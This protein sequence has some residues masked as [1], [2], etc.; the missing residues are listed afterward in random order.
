MTLPFDQTEGLSHPFSVGDNNHAFTAN[1]NATGAPYADI[2]ARNDDTAFQVTENLGKAVQVGNYP[3]AQVY[4]LLQVTPSVEWI[5]LGTTN[6]IDTFLELTDVLETTYTGF[7]LNAVR[8]NAAGTGL[9]FTTDDAGDVIGPGSSVDNSV[10]TFDGLTGKII[11]DQNALFITDADRVGI[12]INLPDSLLHSHIGTA[13][14]VSPLAGTNLTLES[15]TTQYLSF[16]TPDANTSG[17]LFGHEVNNVHGG[18]FY[19]LTNG[20][21]FRNNGNQNVLCLDQN[22]RVGIGETVPEAKL[23]V[24]LGSAGVTAAVPG[25]TLVLESNT[26]NFLQFFYPNANGG[27][28][29]F[30][31]PDVNIAGAFSYNTNDDFTWAT[32]NNAVKMTLDSGGSLAVGDGAAPLA[33]TSI[34]LKANNA[35]LLLNNL[36]STQRDAL[37]PLEGMTIWNTTTAQVENYDGVSWVA[38][39]GGDVSGPPSSLINSIATFLDASGKNIISTAC[40]IDPITG[41]MLVDSTNGIPLRIRMDGA[42]GNP[43][44]V[45]IEDNILRGQ[46]GYFGSQGILG[47]VT[48]GQIG[49]NTNGG[50]EYA[51]RSNFNGGGHRFSTANAA[52]DDLILRVQIE[53][54]TG[55][56][57]TENINV[58]PGKSLYQEVYPNTDRQVLALSCQDQLDRSSLGNDMALLGSAIIVEGAGRIGKGL[59]LDGSLQTVGRITETPALQ[60]TDK[61]SVEFFIFPNTNGASFCPVVSKMDATAAKGWNVTYQNNTIRITLRD[62]P[63]L[64]DFT[65]PNPPGLNIPTSQWTHVAFTFDEATLTAKT[66]FNGK[67]GDSRTVSQGW[68]DSATDLLLGARFFGGIIGN[69]LDGD[70]SNIFVY[71]EVLELEEIRSHYLDA[72]QFLNQSSL[73]ADRYKITDTTFPLAATG[74]LTLTG[75]ALDTETVTIDTKVY[76]FQTVLTDVDGNVFIGASAAATISNLVQ[77]IILGPGSGVAYAASTTLHP[78][79]KAAI[80]TGDSVDATARLAG[81]QGNAIAT[82]ETLTNG[83]WAN[84]TLTG[85]V[86]AKTWLDFNKTNRLPSRIGV[87]T[88]EIYSDDDFPNPDVGGARILDSGLYLIKDN[89]TTPTKWTIPFGAIVDIRVEAGFNSIITYTGDDTFIT[90]SF[91]ST[92]NMDDFEIFLTGN[93]NKAFDL[94]GASVSDSMRFGTFTFA[95]SG[96]KIAG[97]FTFTSGCILELVGFIGF[98]EGVTFSSIVFGSV[99]SVNF[100]GD[101]TG[102]TPHMNILGSLFFGFTSR[103]TGSFTGPS[104][105]VFFI[106]PDIGANANVSIS[107]T[108]NLGAGS[109]YKSGATGLITAYADAM[110]LGTAIGSVISG[111]GG[112]ARFNQGITNNLFIGQKINIFG[113]TGGNVVYNGDHIV[114]AVGPGGLEW[115]ETSVNFV[116]TGSG[117]FTAAST[118]VTST[119][120]G[121]SELESILITGTVAYNGGYGIY[122]VLTNTFQINAP[123]ATNEATGTWDTG[124]L[125]QKDNRVDTQDSAGSPNSMNVAFG[126]MNANAS[127]TVIASAD[128]YQAMDYNTIV[129]DPASEL[130]TLIDPMEGIFRYDGVRPVTGSLVASITATKTGSTAIFRFT[131]SINGAVPTF[132]SK[133]YVPIE[134]KTTQVS[135]TLIRPISVVPGD[136]IQ[137]MG[138]EETTTDNITITHFFLQI[139]I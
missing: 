105:S 44:L 3:T 87:Q 109:Y 135:A 45:N 136:T 40:T 95:G 32:V 90:G 122:N 30:G 123:F 53:D 61:L 29:L 119:A 22:G 8:V 28:L 66:Y 31:D 7:E 17:I 81:S 113:F 139:I 104:E 21:Q 51:S 12:G 102:T 55:D 73:I 128:T 106:N 57:K 13:G 33:D 52:L 4:M 1:P 37:T 124:S 70:L 68:T 59:R 134:I 79:V 86:S 49:W 64:T 125:T 100:F 96:D 16:L 18:I 56:M 82:T 25:T 108:N 131:D 36:T 77:A 48:Q 41:Q 20:M 62:D 103:D 27:G 101:G 5:P 46:F 94:T 137:I 99:D 93:D 76:T 71:N 118:T 78:T 9:E 114:T 83:S 120:H 107:R 75:N 2:T 38:M 43:S 97:T 42:S 26:N 91:H 138:A 69:E 67:L 39:G 127:A 111:T 60:F 126:G 89:L 133:A 58:D 6:P 98:T 47:G 72:S 116:A 74:V 65:V 11:Q 50:C 129:Q 34:D 24:K 35:A 15:N 84:P 23:H 92:F 112:L 88:F 19:D 54:I 80:G 115:F 130:W 85:G 14:V 10:P 110:I 117:T 132:A 121:R 63:T